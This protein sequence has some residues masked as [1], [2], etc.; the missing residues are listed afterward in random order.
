MICISIAQASRRFARVDMFNARGQA[1]LV[2]LRL[3]RFDQLPDLEEL[4]AYKRSPV[5]LSCRRPQ[6]GGH[7]RGTEDERRSLLRQCALAGPDF[8]EVELDAADAVPPQ[9]GVKRIIS[10]TNLK[11]TPADVAAIHRQAAFKSP[12]VIRLTTHVRTAGEALP[13]VPVLIRAAVPTVVEGVGPAGVMLT[14][15]AKKL[16]SPWAYAALEEGMETLP[17][18]PTARVLEGIYH[19]RAV[20]RPTRLLGLVGGTEARPLTALVNATLA[21]LGQDVRCLPLAVTSADE[22]ARVAAAVKKMDA[23]LVGAAHRQPFL[24][25]AA[26]RDPSAELAGSADVLVR[27]EGGWRAF[28][29]LGRAAVLAL[30]E[31]MRPRAQ[32]P[33]QPWRGRMALIVGAN[34]TATAVARAVREKGGILIIATRDKDAGQ[35]LARA[36]GARVVAFEALYSTNHDVLIVC[37]EEKLPFKKAEIEPVSSVHPGYLKPSITVL[38]LT[39]LPLPSPLSRAAELRGCPVATPEQVLRSQLAAQ[40]GIVTGQPVAEA[41]V[42]QAWA[43]TLAEPAE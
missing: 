24:E 11:E 39:T 17:G 26:A 16:Q 37:A 12:D 18:Q 22:F 36:V 20:Q 33:A 14:L 5:I 8:L 40:L 25:A 23:A 32:D 4:L 43:R 15:L 30:E 13:L 6:D 7:W 31:V 41:A 27:Q 21:R 1:D 42:H 19:Y 3:D 10:Y 9:P 2:E 35:H 28:D 38:D 34:A 29:T